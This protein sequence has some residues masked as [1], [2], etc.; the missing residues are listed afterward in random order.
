MVLE[1]AKPKESRDPEQGSY[2]CILSTPKPRDDKGEIL[3]K[4]KEIIS[5]NKGVKKYG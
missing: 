3:P 2:S 5:K 1:F 4:Y